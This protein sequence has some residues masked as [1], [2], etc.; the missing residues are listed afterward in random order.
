MKKIF[1][2]ILKILNFKKV[3][4][5]YRRIFF[6]ENIYI[7]NYIKNYIDKKNSCVVSYGDL[8][9]RK[10]NYI[11]FYNNFFLEFFFYVLKIKFFYS[12]T[13]SLGKNICK[14]SIFKNTKYIYLQHSP[15]GLI[16]AYSDNAFQNFDVVQTINKYQVNDMIKLNEHYNKNIK[17]F[18]SK[19]NY[20][21]N[22]YIK[23]FDKYDL[24]I[25]PTWDTNFYENDFF[26]NL[27]DE[28]K[29]NN[30][31]YLLRPHPMSIKKKEIDLELIK[32][33][34]INFDN[35]I[36]LNLYP[37]KNLISDWSG[38]IFEFFYLKKRKPILIET[39]EKKVNKSNIF[40]ENISFE[41]I[42]RPKISTILKKNEI[43]KIIKILEH[44]EEDYNTEKYEIFF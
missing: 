43:F 36:N 28:L 18:R 5:S 40:S 10:N 31:N 21:K 1:Q 32:N 35:S 2:D 8:K 6:C 30:I 20:L 34:Q 9:I 16:N 17:I 12:S 24:L 3:E 38:I 29:K 23:T 13:P 39:K 11:F 27:V 25:A 44:P 42:M 41:K 7:Y 4:L 26:F 19:C 37:F 15:V 14:K 33:K 22:I